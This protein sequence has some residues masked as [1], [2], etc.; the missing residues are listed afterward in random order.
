MV[1]LGIAARTTAGD[2]NPTQQLSNDLL[3]LDDAF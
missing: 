3:L 1:Q 2:S